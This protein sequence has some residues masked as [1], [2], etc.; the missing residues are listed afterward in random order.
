[1]APLALPVLFVPDAVAAQRDLD[2]RRAERGGNVLLVEPFDEVV[3]R[4]ATIRDRRRYVSPSQAI[5]DLLTGP[6]RSPEE[7]AQLLDVLGRD[8]QGWTG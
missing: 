1:M 2:L 3:Y 7:G 4:D 8:D 5:V 6:G